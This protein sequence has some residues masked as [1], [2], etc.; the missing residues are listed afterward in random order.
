MQIDKLTLNSRFFMGTANYPSLQILQEAIIAADTEV[1]TV[2]LTRAKFDAKDNKFFELL[3]KLPCRVLPNTAGCYSAKDAINTACLAREVFN[4]QWIKLEVI[5]DDYTLQPNSLELLKAA[6]VLIGEG[7]TVFPFC[8]DDVFICQKLV[9]LGCQ[10]LMP[11]AAPIG[12]GQGL[13][14]PFNLK[15]L[16]DRFADVILIIDAGIGRP[17]HAALAMELGYDAILLNSAISQAVDPVTM[18]KAFKLAVSAGRAAYEAG[19]MPE[20]DFAVA[21]T[22]YFNRPFINEREV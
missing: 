22:P 4:T 1:I 14:N 9:E 15:L 12:S 16:R 2:S 11:M 20:R 3:G 17:S 6:E 5:A 21:S 19:I 7:F 18:A 10:I 8:T 13:L